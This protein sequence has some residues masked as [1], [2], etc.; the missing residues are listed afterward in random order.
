MI[1]LLNGCSSAGKSSLARE[2]QRQLPEPYF[3]LGLDTFLEPL[4]PP[5]CNFENPTEFEQV[6]QASAGFSQ[7]IGAMA[8]RLNHLIVDHVLQVPQWQIETAAALVGLPVCFVGVLAPLDVLEARESKRH[9][10]QPGTARQ[11]FEL[12][13]SY[14]YDLTVKTHLQTPDGCATE[15][16]DHLAPGQ[17]L[18]K[19]L[20][21]Q[22]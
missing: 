15:I 8:L 6:L 2:L 12:I 16:M 3:L 11:Q 14:A 10:R 18:W 4:L 1:I 17:A 20:S 9:D 19:T 13:Q 21:E 5:G 7:V 22:I